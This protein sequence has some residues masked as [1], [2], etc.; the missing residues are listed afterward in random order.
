[1]AYG[2]IL[3]IGCV[4]S[5]STE[6]QKII[7]KL[8]FDWYK[9]GIGIGE[10]VEEINNTLENNNINFEVYT[11]YGANYEKNNLYLSYIQYEDNE[12]IPNT[13]ERECAYDAITFD[14]LLNI[15]IRIEYEKA[16][17]LLG[18]E[19]KPLIVYA[20]YNDY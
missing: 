2:A 12:R 6:L 16:L 17:E 8:N 7:K 11:T 9:D 15:D 5:I 13:E 10:L 19:N 20:T 18:L 3:A 14:N 1:M 4:I